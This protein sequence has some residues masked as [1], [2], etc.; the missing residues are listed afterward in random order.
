MHVDA[1]AKRVIKNSHEPH[2]YFG[3]QPLKLIPEVVLAYPLRIPAL[4]HEVLNHFLGASIDVAEVVI[5]DPHADSQMLQQIRNLAAVKVSL[6]IVVIDTWVVS[7]AMVGR[8][9][10]VEDGLGRRLAIDPFK[11]H[12]FVKYK[13]ACFFI[14]AQSLQVIPAPFLQFC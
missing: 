9:R 5:V 10:H 12:N 4:C 2:A 7:F 6:G 11:Q 1:S 3:S 14:L 8:I 13:L